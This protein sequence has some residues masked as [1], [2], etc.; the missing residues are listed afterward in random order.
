MLVAAAIDAAAVSEL[1]QAASVAVA[2]GGL[3]SHLLLL[4][5][6]HAS[7]RLVDALQRLWQQRQPHQLQ[8]QQRL[9]AVRSY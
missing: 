7:C 4:P 5:L 6:L 8:Q 1:A 3:Q 9:S 2:A